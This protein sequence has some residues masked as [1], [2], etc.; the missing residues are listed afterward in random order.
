MAYLSLG[1]PALEAKRRLSVQQQAPA[2]LTPAIV[3]PPSLPA[4]TTPLIIGGLA[5]AAVAV[6]FILK[7]KG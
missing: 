2:T 7:R 3:P 6:F 5:V 4:S 1:N